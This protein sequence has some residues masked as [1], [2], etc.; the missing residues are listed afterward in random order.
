MKPSWDKLA[1]EFKGS[2]SVV[3]ADVDCTDEYGEDV[4]KKFNV[5]G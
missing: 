1:D 5:T 2:D 4:C 3:I